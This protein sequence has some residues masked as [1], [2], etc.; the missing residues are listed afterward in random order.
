MKKN[1][2]LY[3]VMFPLWMILLIAPTVWIFVL[4]G[5]FIIDSIVLVMSL[6][7]MKIADKRSFYKKSI[8][9]VFLS[10]LLADFIGS[11]F[12]FCLIYFFELGSMG[13][14]FYITIPSLV[15]SMCFIYILNYFISF[16]RVEG[17]N[18]RRLS[19][20]FTLVTAPYTFLVPSAW[21]YN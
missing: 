18:R 4:P 19:L 2:R 8:A 21:I 6:Y 15:I 14:E 12:A 17:V 11:L 9:A 3:N 16:K 1:I 5:N 20:V 10:G 7:A 13:D